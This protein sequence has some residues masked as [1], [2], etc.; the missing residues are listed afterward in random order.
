MPGWLGTLPGHARYSFGAQFAE[1]R[2]NADTGEEG[3][4]VIQTILSTG[5]PA[6]VAGV[7]R[8]GCRYGRAGP[9][10]PPRCA[11]GAVG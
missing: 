4:S 8:A 3:E 5:S 1:V 10:S 6:R 2:V 11:A 7:T 9:A